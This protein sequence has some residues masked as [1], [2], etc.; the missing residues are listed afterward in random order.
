MPDRAKVLAAIDSAHAARQA[1]DKE[2]LAR[3]FAPFATFHIVGRKEL[4][5]FDV[6]P[7]DAMSAIGEL[8]DLF[9]FHRMER[10]HVAIDGNVAVI[11]ARIEVSA[12]GGV[13]ETTELCDI[14]T[15]DD[16]AKVRSIVEFA[17]TALMVKMLARAGVG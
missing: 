11:H 4:L 10:I 6:G 15:F 2:A 12:A 8:I 14:W 16:D 7:V 5:G 9:V 13:R 17:D 3:H 1:G